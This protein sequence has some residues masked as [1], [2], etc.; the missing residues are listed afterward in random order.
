VIYDG[1]DA[2]NINNSVQVGSTINA[3]C[4]EGYTRGTGAVMVTGKCAASGKLDGS[5]E[6]CISE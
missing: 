3:F 4:T 1:L 2:Y 6:E 5:Y